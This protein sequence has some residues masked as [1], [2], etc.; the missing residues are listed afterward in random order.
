MYPTNHMLAEVI[1]NERLRNPAVSPVMEFARPQHRAPRW[2]R[3]RSES[4]ASAPGKPRATEALSV[5]L[6]GVETPT[7]SG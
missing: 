1:N 5:R 7:L 2:W 4:R 6:R 3:L